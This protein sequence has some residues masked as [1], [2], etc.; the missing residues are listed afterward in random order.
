MKK[1]L[2]TAFMLAFAI[3]LSAQTVDFKNMTEGQSG[4]QRVPAIA[5]NAQGERIFVYRG[6]D[7]KVHFRHYKN[8]TWSK[9]A[10]IPGSPIFTGEFWYD[11][12]IADYS[13]T[14][15]YV[16]EEASRHMYYAYF[17][18]GAW[19]NMKQVPVPH[20]A[21]LSLGVRSNDTIVLVSA[22]F[23]KSP[24]ITKDVVIGTKTKDQTNFSNFVNVTKDVEAST[25]VDMAV[26]A[27]D[28]SWVVYKDEFFKNNSMPISL[29]ELNRENKV[30]YYKRVSELEESKI[31][32][33]YP[34][35]GINS[36]GLVLVTWYKSQ[37][38]A[39]FSRCFDP[40]TEKWSEVKQ[41]VN[42]PMRP[43]PMM[44]N[45][46]LPRGADFFWVGMTPDR[47]IRLFKYDVA[48]NSWTRIA[49][50]SSAGAEWLN[51]CNGADSILVSWDTFAE[52]VDSFLTTISADPYVAT[53]VQSVVNLTVDKRVERGF[54]HGYTLN[55]LTWEANPANVENEI[56]V[57]A[58]KLYRKLRTED[59]SKWALLTQLG[60]DVLA[61]DDR[62]IPA[63]SDYVYAVTCVDENGVESVIAEESQGESG[64][65]RAPDPRVGAERNDR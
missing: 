50:A 25:M 13:G 32:C 45:V 61:Y 21:T 37:S 34:R 24:T 54:F 62:N 16:C 56:V 63:G 28:N 22:M 29:L 15:H 51:A 1:F 52:P 46:V 30:I 7:L 60:A 18:N 58:Q 36:D 9:H 43:W 19:S 6:G 42:G 2:S 65:S 47:Y 12:I 17:K 20:E 27:K 48:E 57:T 14:I 35:I 31:W 10:I 4:N 39:Y 3:G 8:G 64:A 38:S 5:E 41:I 11:D 40:V 49:N 23:A 59:A 33:W 53:R 55:A 26:D 44:Y